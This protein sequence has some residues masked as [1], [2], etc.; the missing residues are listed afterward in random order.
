MA[1]TLNSATI[2]RTQFGDQ[3]PSFHSVIPP[4]TRRSLPFI[5]VHKGK[6]VE[7]NR[8][9]ALELLQILDNVPTLKK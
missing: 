9:R 3:C 6:R 2:S 7:L 8:R 5:T 4:P 1:N